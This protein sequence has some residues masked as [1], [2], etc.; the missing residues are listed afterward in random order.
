MT[1]PTQVVGR[2]KVDSISDSPARRSGYLANLI[3]ITLFNLDIE[4]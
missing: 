3:A 1:Q 4:T 2:G